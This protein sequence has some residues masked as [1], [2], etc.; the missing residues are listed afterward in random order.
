MTW[1]NTQSCSCFTKKRIFNAADFMSKNK[2]Q[3]KFKSNL[4][5]MKCARVLHLNSETYQFISLQKSSL[6]NRS[7]I[8]SEQPAV[9]PHTA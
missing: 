5:C 2:K 1:L 9:H 6:S 7:S 4:I 3:T 8:H